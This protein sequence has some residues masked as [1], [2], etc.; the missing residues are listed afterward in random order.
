M[1]VCHRFVIFICLYLKSFL[2]GGVG[3]YPYK[4]VCV[5]AH[6][7]VSQISSIFESLLD[8]EEK[9]LKEN[10]VTSVKWAEVVLNVNNIIKVSS[11]ERR[12]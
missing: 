12:L 5:C 9:C 1:C 10:S 4:Y 7:Q 6:F 2:F 8:E 3:R 11:F